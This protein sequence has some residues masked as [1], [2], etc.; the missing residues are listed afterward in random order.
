[1]S[2]CKESVFDKFGI[3]NS[4][5]IKNCIGNNWYNMYIKDIEFYYDPNNLNLGD[6]WV[7][8]RSDLVCTH[9]ELL[10]NLEEFLET[11]FESRGLPTYNMR[12]DDVDADI[13][14]NII[15]FIV[16]EDFVKKYI[17]YAKQHNNFSAKRRKIIK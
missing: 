7:H 4:I 11:F 1:M 14:D 15:S 2:I 6:I 8:Y 12:Y 16:C 5:P 10:D 13:N 3:K 17:N 9:D